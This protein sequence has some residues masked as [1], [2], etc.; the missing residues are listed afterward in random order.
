[1][2]TFGQEWIV[3]I[4]KPIYSFNTGFFKYLWQYEIWSS[5]VF[6]FCGGLILLMNNKFSKQELTTYMYL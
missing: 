4:L 1:M 3:F 6:L 2:K 5:S